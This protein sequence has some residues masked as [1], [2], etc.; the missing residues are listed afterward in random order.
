MIKSEKSRKPLL[1]STVLSKNIKATGN[2][3]SSS[4]ILIEGRFE[5]SLQTPSHVGIAKSADVSFSILSCGSAEIAGKASGHITAK[6]RIEA[7]PSASIAAEIEAPIVR[8]PG[9]C[10]FEGSITTS[11]IDRL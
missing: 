4:S 9:S 6:E 10:K 7:L 2:L 3:T 8:I 11:M 5:G 1:F